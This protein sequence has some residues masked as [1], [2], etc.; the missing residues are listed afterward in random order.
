MIR[1]ITDQ[2]KKSSLLRYTQK[3]H[4]L[5]YKLKFKCMHVY[6]NMQRNKQKKIAYT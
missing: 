3:I 4:E 2:T 1:N 6:I 5:E